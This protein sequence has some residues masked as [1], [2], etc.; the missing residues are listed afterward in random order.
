MT[1]T[2]R[3]APLLLA[4]A[5]CGGG[6]NGGDEAR[7]ADVASKAG[8]SSSFSMDETPCRA[9]QVSPTSPTSRLI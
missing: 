4:L 2:L 8:C 6:D 3:A 9:D 1:R 5:A 7:P